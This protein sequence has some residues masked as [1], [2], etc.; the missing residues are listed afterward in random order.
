MNYA[1]HVG[2]RK[3]KPQPATEKVRE[4]QVENNTGGFTFQITIWDKLTRFLILGAEGG[5]YYVKE[6]DLV[7]QNHASILACIKADGLIEA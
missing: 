7:K 4:D 3:R 1:A 5:T 6:R 2:T